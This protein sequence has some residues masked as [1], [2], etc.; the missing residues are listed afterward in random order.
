MSA[1]DFIQCVLIVG[2]ILF[3]T[4]VDHTRLAVLQEINDK[5]NEKAVDVGKPLQS[6]DV[7]VFEN[8]VVCDILSEVKEC[9]DKGLPL[10]ADLRAAI[11]KVLEIHRD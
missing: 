7:L 10:D 2:F 4:L 3:D 9:I 6:Q 1:I 8:K 11:D 5:L